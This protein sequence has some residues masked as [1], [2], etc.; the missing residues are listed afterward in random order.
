MF[1]FTLSVVAQDSIIL[2]VVLSSS[3]L[4]EEQIASFEEANPDIQIELIDWH[5]FSYDTAVA[6]DEA[7]DVMR[8]Q[9]TDMPQL[10]EDGLV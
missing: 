3:E 9:A 5:T 8:V 10:V 2:R 1:P 7:P 6:L 4:S